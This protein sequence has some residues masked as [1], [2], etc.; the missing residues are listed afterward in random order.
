MAASE[1]SEQEDGVPSSD[2]VA[3]PRSSRAP[4][5]AHAVLADFISDEDVDDVI[6]LEMTNPLL[7]AAQEPS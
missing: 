2:G 1:S 4:G 5:R 7:T 6:T 3:P